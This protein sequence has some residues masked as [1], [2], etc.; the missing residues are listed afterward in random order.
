MALPAKVP[1]AG[2]CAK[3]GLV[4][5][6]EIDAAFIFMGLQRF[7]NESLLR[8]EIRRNAAGG[9]AGGALAAVFSGDGSG[10]PCEARVRRSGCLVRWPVAGVAVRMLRPRWG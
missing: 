5:R 6:L 1:A 9:S 7:L 2:G 3:S 8:L 10:S 4:L